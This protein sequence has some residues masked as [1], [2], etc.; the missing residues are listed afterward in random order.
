LGDWQRLELRAAD[1]SRP[2]TSAHSE[3]KKLIDREYDDSA[4]FSRKAAL[5]ILNGG[6]HDQISQL[7]VHEFVREIWPV[8][9]GNAGWN[10]RSYLKTIDLFKQAGSEYHTSAPVALQNVYNENDETTFSYG[11][12]YV[13]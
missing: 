6:A 7:R 4:V 11:K 5:A 3:D 1:A 9:L 2:G 8:I 13:S 10:W 12:F